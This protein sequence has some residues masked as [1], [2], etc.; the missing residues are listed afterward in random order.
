MEIPIRVRVNWLYRALLNLGP[1]LFLWLIFADARGVEDVLIA[2]PFLLFSLA[3]AA[4]SWSYVEADTDR[5]IV[6]RAPLWKFAIRWDEMRRI[7]VGTNGL[8][9]CG[10]DKVLV[11]NLRMMDGK[12]IALWGF[13]QQQAAKRNLEVKQVIT[14]RWTQKNTRVDIRN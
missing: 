13:F 6:F 2:I 14:V 4:L 5:V 12:S 9:F 1:L 3:G 8:A 11:M 10:D 7:E